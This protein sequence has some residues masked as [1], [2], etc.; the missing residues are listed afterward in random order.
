VNL[1]YGKCFCF[2]GSPIVITSVGG[3]VKINDVLNW[4]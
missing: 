3:I 2:V 1:L 4:M